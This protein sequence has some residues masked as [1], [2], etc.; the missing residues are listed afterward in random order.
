M[1]GH[2]PSARL[3][4]SRHEPLNHTPEIQ[5]L[6]RNRTL[7]EEFAWPSESKTQKSLYAFHDAGARPWLIIQIWDM[8]PTSYP[9][10]HLQHIFMFNMQGS[11]IRTMRSGKTRSWELV[12][13]QPGLIKKR[14]PT[15][16]GKNQDKRLERTRI[17]QKTTPKRCCKYQDKFRKNPDWSENNADEVHTSSEKNLDEVQII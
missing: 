4:W 6:K 9:E 5:V 12:Q 1:D 14:T 11:Y 15:R 16:C 7:P 3:T 10:C 8:L 2:E 17:D 13:K